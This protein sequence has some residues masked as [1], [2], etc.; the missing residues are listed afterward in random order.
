MDQSIPNPKP[1]LFKA[2]ESFYHIPDQE[3]HTQVLTMT[4]FHGNLSV[5]RAG[6]THHY[7]T[8][9]HPGYCIYMPTP[10]R[11]IMQVL[12]YTNAL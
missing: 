2:F 9:S 3:A 8:G 12:Q 6:E 7:L 4:Y 10:I 1:L 11:A 5:K